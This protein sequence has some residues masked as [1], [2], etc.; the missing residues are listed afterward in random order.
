MRVAL[1]SRVST[2]E[3]NADMQ[4]AELRAYCQRRRRSQRNSPT[5]A[6]LDRRR[7]ALPSIVSS[8]RPSAGI[9]LP[10]LSIATTVLRVR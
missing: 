3:Q 9:F 5:A 7:V 10:S 4:I 2:S 8:P 1:Y 6:S